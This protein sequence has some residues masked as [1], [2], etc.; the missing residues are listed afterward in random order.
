MVGCVSAHYGESPGIGAAG[1]GGGPAS[2]ERGI[3]RLVV[4]GEAA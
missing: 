4:D 3:S 1:S 2:T